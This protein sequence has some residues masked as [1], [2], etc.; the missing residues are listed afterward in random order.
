MLCFA[1]NLI[2]PEVILLKSMLHIFSQP[3]TELFYL[4]THVSKSFYSSQFI[5]SHSTSLIGTNDMPNSLNIFFE[6]NLLR[7]LTS[8]SPSVASSTN[9]MDASMIEKT[10]CMS[11]SKCLFSLYE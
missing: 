6:S 8:Y 5:L 4:M 11:K 3:K 10:L 7:S 9:F 1:Y 2:S